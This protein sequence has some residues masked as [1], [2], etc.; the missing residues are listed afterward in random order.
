MKWEKLYA[1][2]EAVEYICK[3]RIPGDIVE[4]GVWKGGCAMLI[5]ETLNRH[6]DKHRLIYLYD[7]FAGMSEPTEKDIRIQTGAMASDKHARLQL[8]SHNEWCYAPLADVKSNV[9]RIKFPIERFRFVEGK[10]ED[11][12]PATMPDEIA[13]LHL[14]T[15]WYESTRHELNH[16]FPRLAKGGIL[17]AD[18][19]GRWLGSRTA[20]DEYL[21]ENGIVMLLTRVDRSVVGVKQH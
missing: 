3:N 15:D 11:T 8:G 9:A 18:D 5:G 16:L 13:L 19:Y 17:I 6:E 4:C 20:V 1:V 12:I 14:D 2:Y 7:T 21:T 10:V